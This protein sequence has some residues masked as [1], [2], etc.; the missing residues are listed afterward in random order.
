[1]SVKPA[2]RARG[3]EKSTDHL[4][5]GTKSREDPKHPA[6]QMS[7]IFKKI[8]INPRSIRHRHFKQQRQDQ[9]QSHS[10]IE[11]EE[12]KK[13][14]LGTALS[15]TFSTQGTHSFLSCPTSANPFLTYPWHICNR[16]FATLTSPR[17]FPDRTGELRRL[18]N[19]CAHCSSCL[20]CYWP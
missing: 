8:K 6:T 10:E 15:P 19:R 3:Q 14:K 2:V 11:A 20:A 4:Y 13:S 18:F 1:M 9:E 16:L 5:L 17:M 7:N 12:R